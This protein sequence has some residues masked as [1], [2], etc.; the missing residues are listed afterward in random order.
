MKIGKIRI[1]DGY[2]RFHDLTIDLGDNPKRI[3]ALVGPNGCG[4]SS[5][6]DAMLYHANAHH[7]LG[8]TRGK[9]HNYHSMTGATTIDHKVVEMVIDGSTF[10]ELF[11]R[12]RSEGSHTS[13]FSFRSPYRYNADL[14]VKAVK[15]TAEIR[16]N[17]FGASSCA[18]IDQKMEENYRRL[19]AY[20]NKTM[21]DENL[22]PSEAKERIIGELNKS[23]SNC[24]D[25]T[26][27]DLGNIE[28]GRGT[29]YFRKDDQPTS[30]EFNVLSS[31]EKEVV[32]IILD[33]FL[34][35]EAYTD[36]IFLIDEPELHINT[37][38]Q[39][40]LLVEIDR[41]IGDNCQIW[42]ST[43]SIGFLRALQTELRESCSVVEFEKDGNYASA[44]RTLTPMK[45]NFQ[46]WQKLFSVPL[47]DL[48]SLVCPK[49][50]IYCEGRDAPGANG[51][52]RGLDA[53]FF[54]AV[55][56]S[57]YPDTQFVSS[58]G[59]TELDQRSAI[60]VSILSKALQDLVVFVLKDR[61]AGSGSYMDL[62]KRDEYLDLNEANHRMLIRLEIENYAFDKEVV[63]AYCV[64][65]GVAFDEA[66]Y[67]QHIT[68]IVNE[69]VKDKVGV[70]KNI[71]GITGSISADRFKLRLAQHLTEELDLFAELEECI[72]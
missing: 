70:V 54:N 42:I 35:K 7:P 16:L 21:H 68:D 26:I 52:E 39:R 63:R 8:N 32:D 17:S 2:K 43:H 53:Q 46:A 4:K 9:D 65:N 15:A 59:N 71:C 36:T 38:I 47:D 31:G 27:D 11:D 25:M 22:R 23:I 30:F 12:R 29:L 57:K 45:P 64:A 69:D 13:I 50:I 56:S 14:K 37:S 60:A 28:S 44:T 62:T 67:D 5:V 20:Y 18:D 6:F 10:R 61:D 72:F 51:R 40:N 55:F 33:L 66:T 41:L 49:R 48:A 58:G 24:L 1:K 34:R 3:I 19:N